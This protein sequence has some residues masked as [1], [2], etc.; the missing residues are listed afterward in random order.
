MDHRR[1]IYNSDFGI[2]HQTFCFSH[3]TS[4]QGCHV[5]YG[6]IFWRCQPA[7]VANL[8]AEIH[9]VPAANI[10]MFGVKVEE[11]IFEEQSKNVIF[12]FE[13]VE[14]LGETDIS[15]SPTKT[16]TEVAI[17]Q[18]KRTWM[19]SVPINFIY[20]V[21]TWLSFTSHDNTHKALIHF[22]VETSSTRDPFS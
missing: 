6:L 10:L 2:S 1:H 9:S 14:C 17:S 15:R 20:L 3:V 22:F 11:E 16:Q 19:V 7:K 5:T 21:F 12:A 8:T 4:F 18:I 13:P